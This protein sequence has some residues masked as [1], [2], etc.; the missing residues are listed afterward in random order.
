MP[1]ADLDVVLF[2]GSLVLSL[3]AAVLFLWLMRSG[4]DREE[5]P[6]SEIRNPKTRAGEAPCVG[7]RVSNFEFSSPC[8]EA[9][10]CSMRLLTSGSDQLTPPWTRNRTRPLRFTT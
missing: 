8:Y 1:R 4:K 7:F 6:K 2:Y 10:S 3:A 5:N 9:S